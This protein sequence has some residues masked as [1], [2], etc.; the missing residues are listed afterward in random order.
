[1]IIIIIAMVKRRGARSRVVDYSNRLRRLNDRKIQC[2]PGGAEARSRCRLVF[3]DLTGLRLISSSDPFLPRSTGAGHGE[4]GGGVRAS[5][6]RRRPRPPRP[7][8]TPG[9][10]RRLRYG[11]RP[12]PGPRAAARCRPCI[13][14][15]V[16]EDILGY[17]RICK[18]M[19]GYAR[20]CKDMSGYGR[21]SFEN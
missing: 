12:A 20:I 13:W 6:R 17:A 5:G 11:W 18:D 1:M 8:P 15:F 3:K 7:G 2:W 14:E 19:Q 10:C 9:R 21:I 4:L 16:P